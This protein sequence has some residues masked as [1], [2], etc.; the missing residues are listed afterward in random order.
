MTLFNGTIDCNKCG[1]QFTVDDS[2]LGSIRD[3]DLE[4]QYF[5]CPACGVKYHVLTTNGKMRELIEQRKVVQLKIRLASTKKFKERTF[6][7]YLREYERFKEEQEKMRPEL[8]A[9]GERF[10]EYIQTTRT[11][12]DSI[13]EKIEY[14]H[15]HETGNT[16]S[17]FLKMTDEEYSDFIKTSKLPKRM[18]DEKE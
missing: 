3:G 16:L 14:W 7:K 17:E 13:D 1:Q 6:K 5:S 11:E 10:L 4:I 2:C 9:K 18:E 8:K 15:T 12:A